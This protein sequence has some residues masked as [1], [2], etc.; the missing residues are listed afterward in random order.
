[1]DHV[2]VLR[3]AATSAGARGEGSRAVALLRE[4][5]AGVDPEAD[6]VRAAALYSGSGTSSARRARGRLPTAGLIFQ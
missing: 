4:A 3:L 1:M 6:P 5:L 2:E